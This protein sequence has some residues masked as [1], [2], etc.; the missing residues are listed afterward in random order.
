MLSLTKDMDVGVERSDEETK[1]GGVGGW[2]KDGCVVA[3]CRACGGD[4]QSKAQTVPLQPIYYH[5][6]IAY[7]SY[8]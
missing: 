5:P 7:L 8:P 2:W 1:L 4:I 6:V 3:L